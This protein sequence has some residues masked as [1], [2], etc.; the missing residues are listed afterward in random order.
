MKI[1]YLEAMAILNNGVFDKSYSTLSRAEQYVVQLIE[2][3]EG[4]DGL[5]GEREPVRTQP[6]V[7]HGVN[8]VY[9]SHDDVMSEAEFNKR[10]GKATDIQF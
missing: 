4:I 9:D 6:F 2:S 7:N 3:G 5:P 10:F 1:T 8:D